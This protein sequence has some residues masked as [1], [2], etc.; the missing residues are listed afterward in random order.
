MGP[1]WQPARFRSLPI[2][3]P[4]DFSLPTIRATPLSQ[5]AFV[6]SNRAPNYFSK[7]LL[8]SS[9]WVKCCAEGFWSR[10]SFK[11]ILPGVKLFNF[12]GCRWRSCR[13]S[14]LPLDARISSVILAGSVVN[15]GRCRPPL[16][17]KSSLKNRNSHRARD[18]LAMA[19]HIVLVLDNFQT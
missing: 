12:G 4:P 19:P 7:R 16:W 9:F 14:S 17:L 15:V 10:V 5:N 6:R 8:I 1:D 3:T 18:V 2:R 11:N 13:R